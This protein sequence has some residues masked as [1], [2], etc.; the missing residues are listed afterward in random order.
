LLMNSSEHCYGDVFCR[1][2]GTSCSFSRSHCAKTH[3]NMKHTAHGGDNPQFL[4]LQGPPIQL[5]GFA[6]QV[7]LVQTLRTPIHSQ[8][9]V[10]DFIFWVF[11]GAEKNIAPLCSDNK[12]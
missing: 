2:T 3:I 9:N 1:C 11:L 4:V 12:K 10:E 6:V 8:A 7:R 5:Q